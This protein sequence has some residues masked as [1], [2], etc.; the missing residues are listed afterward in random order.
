[1]QNFLG[2]LKNRGG[3][4]FRGPVTEGCPISQA[5]SDL[6]NKKRRLRRLYNNT[7]DPC[8]KSTKNKLQKEIRTKINQ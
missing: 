2:G 3:K 8:T 1:M 4:A 5:I 6:I 7:H